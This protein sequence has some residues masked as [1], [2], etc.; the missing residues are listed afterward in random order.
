MNGLLDTD[1]EFNRALVGS[2]VN[3]SVISV[4]N[5]QGIYIPISCSSGFAAMMECSPEEYLVK[6]REDPFCTVLEEDRETARCLLKSGSSSQDDTHVFI[7]KIT[8]KGK[9]LRVDVN[10]AFFEYEGKRYVC[11]N[12]SDISGLY[13]RLIKDLDK[14]ESEN[15]AKTDFMLNMSQDVSAHVDNIISLN[16]VTLSEDE[17]S[18]ATRLRLEDLGSSAGHLQILIN[19]IL[20]ISRIESGKMVLR[21]EE[22]AFG[23]LI[24]HINTT[25][26]NQCREKNIDYKCFIKGD[27]D[28]YYVGDDAKLKKVLL[29][30]LGNAV[31]FT[32]NDGHISM[33][34]ERLNSF[35][36]RSEI[37]FTVRDTGIG[38][39]KDFIPKMFDIFTREHDIKK[40][41]YAGSGL[42]MAITKR[43]VDMMNGKIEVKSEKR[44]GTE[45]SVSVTLGDSERSVRAFNE[46]RL[47]ELD[48]LVIDND[49]VFCDIA[50]GILTDAGIKTGS[51]CSG[52]EAIEQ[53][54]LR[55]ARNELYD[56]VLVDLHMPGDNGIEI[57]RKIRNI[58]GDN[59][60]IILTGYG[61]DDVMD[62]AADAGADSFLAKPLL[63][64][65]AIDVFTRTI[66]QKREKAILR[67]RDSILD[68]RHILLVVE[69]PANGRILRHLLEIKGIDTEIVE[70]G[71][72][73]MKA[74]TVKER[75]YFDA[76]LMDIRMSVMDGL[77]A[78]VMIRNLELGNK[79]F[80]PIIALTANKFN[81]DEI[82][83]SLQAGM[84][85]YLSK[86]IEAE[87]MF[88]TLAGLIKKF[89]KEKQD[90]I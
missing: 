69:S 7:R 81:D 3:N 68:G 40:G 11:C 23:L 82:R 1:A 20:D 32:D 24:D 72:E 79:A 48:V 42:G 13:D 25:I 52:D 67:D 34:A 14:A 39:D 33:V 49:P 53:I 29:S 57:T 31:K 37:C 88:D 18:P 8:M 6:E 56:I 87:L 62:E 46:I 58:A 50:Q 84:N 64:A 65:A 76:V 15:A 61:W 47:H 16:S 60:V 75:Y 45:V 63:P 9:I 77:D 73:A 44:K 36:G 59:I 2:L 43:I 4:M 90:G 85:A 22:F 55:N 19:N 27:F 10:C 21:N 71:L 86:P 30:I 70:N 54:R 78:A 80:T 83:Y 66:R 28:D 17:L 26:S 5:D 38:M 89:D 41:R 35:E 51:V 12:Y 74:F